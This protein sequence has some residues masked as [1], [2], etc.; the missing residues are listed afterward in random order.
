[1]DK[2]LFKLLLLFLISAHTVFSQTYGNEWISYDQKYYTFPIV[3]SGIY[4]LDYS[5][6]TA[7]GIP[8][9]TFTSQNIQIFGREKEVALHIEDGGD[10]N[11]DPGDYILFYAEK[12]DSWLDSTLFL[13]PTTVGNPSYSLVNDTINYFFTWNSLSTNLRYSVETS[14]DF[15]SYTPSNFILQKVESS[16]GTFYNLAGAISTTVGVPNQREH[17]SSTSF[18]ASGEGFGLA[19]VNGVLNGGYTLNL[20]VITNSPYVG[21]DAPLVQF[22]GIS[23]SHSEGDIEGFFDHH[24]NW[25]VGASDLVLWDRLYNDYDVDFADQ[26]FSSSVLGSGITSLKWSIIADQTA[27]TDYQ[28][29]NYWSII[30]PK[31]PTLDGTSSGK[32]K[33]KN[34]V[35]QSK[36]RLDFTNT[37]VTNPIVFVTGS[38]PVKANL[39]SYNGGYSTLINNSSNNVD[40]QVVIQDLS[41]VASVLILKPV[42]NSGLTPGLFTDFSLV[43]GDSALLMI[44]HK[45]LILS[46]TAYE[47]YRKSVEGGGFVT[48]MANID[49]LYLQFGGGINKHINSVRRFTH[50]MYNHSVVK[51]VGLFL[52][53]KSVSLAN[54]GW[55]YGSNGSRTNTVSYALNLIPTFGEPA[56]DIAITSYLEGNKWVPLI[57]VG[58]VSM[59]TDQE[60]NDYLI[61]VKEFELEQNPNS[62]YNSDQKDW[63]KHILHFGGGANAGQQS[64]FRD[65]LENMEVL[66]ED[67]LY[68]GEVTSY[69]KTSSAPINPGLLTE[70]TNRIQEGIS[71]MT[72][73]GHASPS[74][75]SGFDI[76]ID[77]PSTWNNIGKYPII[78]GNSCWVGNMFVNTSTPSVSERF[79]NI[80]QSGAIA[81]IGASSDALD[82]PS[83]VY[84]I[85]LYSQFSHSSYGK[86]L[87]EQLK[88][89]V[90]YMEGTY[91]SVLMYEATA[92]QM[93]LLGDPMLRLNWHAKPEI[94]LTVDKVSFTPENLDLTVD[95]IGITIILKNLGKSIVDTFNIEVIRDF[96]MLNVDSIYNFKVSRLDYID[97]FYFKMLLQ[98]NIGVG[99]NNMTISVDIPSFIPEQYDEITNNKISTTLFI[100]VEGILPVIP[101]DFAVIPV[102][103]V[104]VIGS[105]I[106]PLA[107]YNTYRFEIDTTDLFNSPECRY[108]LKS[109]LGGVKSVNPSEWRL[110]SN[111]QISKLTC[112]DSTVYFWR[113]A[114]DSSV[115]EWRERSFQ[116]IIGKK[117]WGQ[118]HFFQFKKNN[119]LNVNYNRTIREREFDN[120][121][122]DTLR[123]F[124]HNAYGTCATYVNG[125]KLE[126][127][128]CALIPIIH[129]DVIDPITH[130]PW[131]TRYVPTGQ[132][133]NNDFGNSNDNGSCAARPMND[134]TFPSNSTASLDSLQIMLLDVIPDGCYV[135][136]Y[137]TMGANYT[138]WD[139]YSPSMYSTF[140]SLGCDS[141]FPGRANL[142]FSIFFKKGDPSSVIQKFAYTAT[143]VIDYNVPLLNTSIVGIETSPLIGPSS[144]W[145]NVYWKQDS[146][147]LASKD[148]TIL[149]IKVYDSNE[150]FQYEID[151]VFTKNDSILNLNSIVDANLYPFIKLEAMYYDST[152]TYPTP[153]QIDRWHVLYDPLPEAAIDGTGGYTWLPSKD[154]LNEGEMVKFAIDI[155]NIYD[156][157]MDSLLVKYWIEDN[158]HNLHHLVYLRQD[159]LLVNETFRDT[160]EFSTIGLVGINSLWMEVNP[161]VN[162]SFYVTDQP[163]QEHFNNL[164]QVP[165]YVVGDKINPILDVTFDGRHILNGDIIAPK[166]EIFITLKDENP[167]LIMDSVSDTTRFGIYLTGP[168]GVQKRIPFIDGAGNEIMQWIPADAQNRRFKIIFPASFDKDGIYN[169]LVQGTDRSGN[170]SGDIQYKISFEIIKESSITYLMNYPNPFSTST[171][172]VFTLTGSEVPQD[173][174]IQIMTVTGKVVREITESELGPIYIGRNISEYDWNGT[175]EF[176]DPLANGVYLYRVKSRINNE[177][178]KHRDSGADSH[179]TKDFGKMYIMR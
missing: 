163:E 84:S 115:F 37:V 19:P 117:G 154:S 146:L 120:S 148:S 122:P 81:F 82:L 27:L 64:T 22:K 94:E 65:Y 3:N 142:P 86:T 80:P 155:K 42:N 41:T 169:L 110:V 2:R 171:R 6:L 158:S 125:Q 28:S 40:Q 46:S 76:N 140:Q 89:S 100:D 71:L 24:V 147:E 50:F 68:G 175:D 59:K 138:Q 70:V 126:N 114:I 168:D 105:T 103:S 62:V 45:S 137:T 32:F 69:Y 43:N 9:S 161:Y 25:K 1:M 8:L 23:S 5:T 177:E 160:I 18:Y 107:D 159:S 123:S 173:M 124:V 12:N 104:T 44:Y 179:F 4:K 170:I 79:V 131:K 92:M 56:S 128:Y 109:G 47:T 54:S 33:V 7:S 20:S 112:T 143:D 10:S 96:P 93:N 152:L 166:S 26:T 118:D 73:F 14:I 99:I 167:L 57:P 172:F 85:E 133:L 88:N 121:P 52:I 63:Q 87:S 132:N 134:F 139:T 98:P 15:P 127:A 135:V 145:N 106:N 74:V 48:V 77:V 157:D 55:P 178:I 36:I 51:P 102:D 78:L 151:T 17:Y 144:N 21:I 61:K 53:G 108:A 141:I 13:D 11:I 75:G 136:I 35:L 116:Y 164:L 165:F 129:V 58:R 111:N 95:S 34:N 67:S 113:V 49:E 83:A 16:Y 174:I 66:I 60:L 91:N 153:A 29:L 101:H 39:T 31:Q 149:K 38:L 30:Y 150:S 162:G 119:F 72:F 90:V 97:T 176:G 130:L 156:L